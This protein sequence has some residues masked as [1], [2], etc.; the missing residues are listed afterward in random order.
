MKDCIYVLY[1]NLS[2]RY[3]SVMSFPS[4][5]MA[6]TRLDEGKINKEEFTLCRIGTVN[7]I[8]GT[9]EPCAPVR[10]VWNRDE[11]KLPVSEVKENE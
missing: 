4:D 10:L 11:E 2:N 3:V 8:D 9:V 6:L 7:L 1:N 5:A